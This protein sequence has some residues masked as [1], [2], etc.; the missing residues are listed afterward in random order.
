MQT[1]RLL[2]TRIRARGVTAG[3]ALA[4]ALAGCTATATHGHVPG[5]KRVSTSAP[6][7][8]RVP[9]APAGALTPAQIQTAYNLEP[10][11][12]DG[13][14]GRGQTIVIVDPFGSPTIA[15]DLAVFDQRFGLPAPPSLR[16]IQ[17]AGPVPRYQPNEGRAGAAAE[18][19]LDV[20]WA[21]VMAPGANILLVETP[22]A[23]IE[24]RSGFPQIVTAEEYVIRHHLGGVISQSFGATEPTFRSPAVIRQLRGAYQ[25]AASPAYRV[26]VLAASGDNGAAGQTYN[27]RSFFPTPQVGWP[28]SDP[29]VT[30]VGGTQLNLAPDG[31]RLGPDVAWSGSG[32]GR[33]ALFARP[34]YQDGVRDVVGRARGIPDIS[35]DASCSS[36]AVI[37]SSFGPGPPEWST[38]CGTSLATPL[39]AGV[40]ALAGQKAGHPLG[41]INP[42]LYR[43]AASHD[44]GIVDI[45]EGNNTFRSRS[46]GMGQAVQGFAARPGYDLVTGLGTVDAALFVPELA[47]AA[48]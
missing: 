44:R 33:S 4:L 46:G 13:I 10:L 17:P 41:A 23:E 37:Y 35:M 3:L 6:A 38:I 1:G 7:P 26:T 8:G 18:T 48:G 43:M 2:A 12:R 21:H 5:P 34:S 19:T 29:L 45:R 27:T 25:L 32:G 20:D 28:A 36:G 40:V 39:F 47:R 42:A 11:L 22:T 30:A 9:P 15:H 16:V 24:G 31:T 14:D